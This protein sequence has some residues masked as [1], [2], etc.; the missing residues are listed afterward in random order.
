MRKFF[1]LMAIVSLTGTASA[2]V[3]TQVVD[4]KFDGIT[5]KGFLAFDEAVKEKRP[6]ILLV[7]EWWGLN[8]YAK[9]RAEMLAE[10]GYVAFCAD[11]YG[12][13]KTTEHPKEASTMA[14]TVRKN[15]DIWRGRA[16]AA[17]KLLKERPEVDAKKTAAIGYCFGGSTA[18]QLAL[19][20]NDLSAVVSFHGALPTPSVDDA[21]KITCKVLICHGADDAFIP[22]ANIKKFRSSLDEAKVSYQF[23]SYPDAVHS[24]TVKGIDD[25]GVKGLAYNEAADKKSWEQMQTL[26]KD[27]FGKK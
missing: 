7:H 16:E 25:K 13:G 12:D 23:E 17:L 4:Y 24:F 11:M 26:F 18:L 6:G 19:A 1:A 5:L 21:K 20:G 3:K 14:A 2:A 22:E 8:D 15:V 9:K 27:V 10:L